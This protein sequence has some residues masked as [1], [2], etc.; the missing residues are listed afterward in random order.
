[1]KIDFTKGMPPEKVAAGIIR[2]LQKN[3]TETVLGSDARWMLLV[4]QVLSTAHGL[5]DR[6]Q[7]EEAL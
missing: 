3:R 2:G 5:L 6:P 4:E 1:M 7:G